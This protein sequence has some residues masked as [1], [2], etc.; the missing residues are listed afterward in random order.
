MMIQKLA[1]I[2][3]G[4]D[5][6]LDHLGV[7]A[8]IMDMPLFITEEQTHLAALKFYPQVQSIHK[9]AQ[10]LD[11]DFL[12]HHFDALF[13]S[14]KF[15]TMELDPFIRLLHNKKMRFIYCPHGHSD[16]GHSATQF[17]T[18]DISLVYGDHMSDLLTSTGAMKSIGSTVATGNYRFAFYQKYRSFYKPLIEQHITS[19]LD[20]GKKTALYAPSWQDGENPTSFFNWAGRLIQD[21]KKEFNLI[22]KLHPFLKQFH[23]AETFS[24]LERYKNER[25][26]LFLDCFPCIYP[27]L[28][29]CDLYIGDYSSI[30]YDFLSFDRPLYFLLGERAPRFELHACGKIIPTTEDICLFIRNT[31]Q[32]NALGKKE[33]R[34]NLYEYVFGKE[35]S[36][37]VLKQEILRELL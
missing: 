19:K 4:P 6:Y 27:L 34:K 33:T 1:A 16:K 9:E 11:I 37:D 2:V 25:G 10:D 20:P 18:Q 36:F 30:G 29:A 24:I 15:F 5:T 32:E 31:W 13:E 22:I 8:Y 14:G 35:K 12:A 26:V 28:E 23:P 21:L 3:T 7:L 17:A